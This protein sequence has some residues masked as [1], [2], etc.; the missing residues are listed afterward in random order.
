MQHLQKGNMDYFVC[1][2]GGYTGLHKIRPHEFQKFSLSGWGFAIIKIEGEEM[3]T[4]FIGIEGL[5]FCFQF[6]IPRNGNIQNKISFEVEIQ[7]RMDKNKLFSY[8]TSVRTCKFK[9]F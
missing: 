9:D 1:G 2:G 3:T 4:R 6:D 8:G 7:S 5:I